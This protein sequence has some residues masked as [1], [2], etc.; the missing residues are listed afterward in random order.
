LRFHVA[1]DGGELPGRAEFG[2]Q[3]VEHAGVGAAG[4]GAG[5]PRRGQERAGRLGE[6]DG[7]APDRGHGRARLLPC[8]AASA[9]PLVMY[10]ITCASRAAAAGSD[11]L[12]ARG[13]V[14]LMYRITAHYPVAVPGAAR[15]DLAV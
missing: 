14:A 8:H 4:V 15:G 11:R 12:L 3:A 9:V 2:G 1:G 5:R 10:R 13:R 6:G 7:A